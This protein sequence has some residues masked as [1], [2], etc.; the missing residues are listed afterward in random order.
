MDRKLIKCG[1]DILRIIEQNESDTL[2]VNFKK[3]TMPRWVSN[4]SLTEY[5][6]YSEEISLPDIKDIA[7]SSRKKAYE[8]FNIISPVLPYISN[9]S[10]RNKAIDEIAAAKGIS[11]I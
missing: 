11:S 2:I 4:A 7:A 10:L 3:Q 8:R 9:K 5:T 6:P 1:D